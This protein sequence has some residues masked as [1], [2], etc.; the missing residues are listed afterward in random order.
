MVLLCSRFHQQLPCVEAC[1]RVQ[2]HRKAPL[3]ITS[4]RCVMLSLVRALLR[5]F[6]LFLKSS[7]LGRDFA[8][9]FLLA[10]GEPVALILCLKIRARREKSHLVSFCQVSSLGKRTRILPAIKDSL[11]S[12]G[13]GFYL[14]WVWVGLSRC[15]DSLSFQISTHLREYCAHPYLLPW[16]SLATATAPWRSLTKPVLLKLSVKREHWHGWVCSLFFF[17]NSRDEKRKGVSFSLCAGQ[18][19]KFYQW[20]TLWTIS[21]G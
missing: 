20:P 6:S 18:N 5:T 13:K 12:Q 4:R 16:K 21:H 1:P 17:R 11:L 8:I 3:L 10:S 19:A 2:D 15:I 9:I 7:S 14:C